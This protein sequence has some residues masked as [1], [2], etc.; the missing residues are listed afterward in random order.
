MEYYL[1]IKKDEALLHAPTRKDFQNTILSERRQQATYCMIPCIENVPNRQIH[2]NRK[3][4]NGCPG[5]GQGDGL[6][7]S[8]R[9]SMWLLE[10]VTMMSSGE[11]SLTST[12]NS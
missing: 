12:A 2:E 5:L 10:V 6:T 11:K 7:F 1:A 4:I 3:K 8:A 9:T